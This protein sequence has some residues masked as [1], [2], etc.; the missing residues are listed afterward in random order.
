MDAGEKSMLVYKEKLPTDTIDIKYVE[1]P[2]DN[3]EAARRSILHVDLQHGEPCMWYDA[4]EFDLPTKKYLILAVRTG[5]YWGEYHGEDT[6][7]SDMYIGTVLLEGGALVLHYF[8]V[9][10]DNQNINLLL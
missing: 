6:L 1:L 4:K 8:L 3:V 5:D 7:T 2:Y 9:E 10:T